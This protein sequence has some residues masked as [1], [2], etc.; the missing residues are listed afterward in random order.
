MRRIAVAHCLDPE[1]TTTILYSL[2]HHHHRYRRSLQAYLG[3]I[4]LDLA[5]TTQNLNVELC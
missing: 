2:R 1:I 3:V 4:E 5:S